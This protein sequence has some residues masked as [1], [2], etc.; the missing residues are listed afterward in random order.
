MQVSIRRAE[1]QRTL[2]NSSGYKAA[3]FMKRVLVT[4][5]AGF[6]GS[7]SASACWRRVMR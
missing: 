2:A 5:G 7:T 4:G 1:M 3:Y 6:I